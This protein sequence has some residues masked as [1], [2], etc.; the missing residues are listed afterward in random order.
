MCHCSVDDVKETVRIIE[1]CFIWSMQNKQPHRTRLI[2]GHTVDDDGWI[3]LQM[4]KSL[5]RLYAAVRPHARMITEILMIG[6]WDLSMNATLILELSST[7][8]DLDTHDDLQV[9]IPIDVMI[10]NLPIPNESDGVEN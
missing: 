9:Q 4:D 8:F 3:C 2:C 6:P 1:G 5:T 10:Q 7:Y